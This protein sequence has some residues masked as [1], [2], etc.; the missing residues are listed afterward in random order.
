MRFIG[1]KANLTNVINN[2]LIE[3]NV[4]GTS[5]FDFFAGTASVGKFF[6]NLGFKIYS[7]DL[8]Y[9]SYVLQ[10]AYIVNNSQPEFLKLFSSI[11]IQS[12]D[13]FSSPLNSVISFLN[14][15][16]P[17][18]GFIYK[19]FT[20]EGTSYLEIP[21]MYFTGSNGKKIDAIRIEIEK[22]FTNK[23][24]SEDE[25][26]VLL[27]CLIESV[28]FFANISGVYAA[29][30]KSWDP[31]ATK[32]LALREIEII[33]NNFD[34]FSYNLNSLNLLDSI[35]CDILYLDPP[36][37][38]RQYAPNYHLL[39]TIA[40][41]DNPEIKGVSGL[42]PYEKQKSNF[43]NPYTALQELTYICDKSN[44]NYIV[45][46]YNSEG[47][48]PHDEIT[49]ILSRYGKLDFFEFDNLRYKSNSNG[50]SKEKKFIKEQ[51]FIL[52]KKSKP[53]FNDEIYSFDSPAT[54]ISYNDK[55][56]TN[57]KK[58]LWLLTEERPKS[59]VLKII[60]AEFCKDNKVV[61]FIDELRILPILENGKFL[62]KYEVA[63]V[64]FNKINKVFIKIVSGYSSFVDYLI[65][66][67]DNQPNVD[68]IPDY[69]IEETKTDDKESRNTGVYQRASKFVSIERFYPGIKKYMLYNLS[70]EQKHDPTST[71]IFGT[72][73]LLNLGVKIIGKKLD[74]SIFKK[75]DDIDE[76]I[77]FKKNMRKAPKG[78]VAIQ[79]S[80]F[81]NRI[82]VS[83]RLYKSGSIGYDPNIGSLSLIC[84][85]LRKL[86]WDKDIIVTNHGLS[87]KNVG[88]NNKFVKIANKLNI[89][90]SGIKIPEVLDSSVK[91]WKYE[92]EGEKLGTIFIHLVVENFTDGYSI[93]ENHAG[94]EKG[95]FI[96]KDGEP[97]VLEKYKN[98]KKYKAGKKNFIIHI[99]DLILID[100]GK[101]EIINVEGKKY[102]FRA[103]G[104][105]ELKNYD[106]IEKLYIKKHYPEFNIIRTVVL[107]GS[108]EKKIIEIEVGFLLNK[109]GDL[110]LGIKPPAIFKKA[111]KNLIDFWS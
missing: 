54:K 69:A 111:I 102:Q 60:I 15:I 25:Y 62:F 106:A 45:L 96:T 73:L 99:P 83:G 101:S 41:Y 44:C 5:F 20:P 84:A 57:T 1:N 47:I 76:I 74:N 78:N 71:Y 26:F 70:V 23:L 46:S 50:E 109:D 75:F 22:W 31:R 16:E 21:R 18:E 79:I 64:R 89:R 40:K 35:E 86:G 91:Y 30:Q 6:K 95:Y 81:K 36:Y 49:S 43:C 97:I 61:G 39:E 2:I 14:E 68:D 9:F 8:M 105:K 90:L 66:F 4:K 55:N 92:T 10:R 108:I 42:R 58:N 100:F 27:A 48:M 24:I 88:G 3:H 93:F 87:Q 7:S 37:N 67:M 51:I 19:N 110:I 94:C 12:S 53:V 98:R 65:F 103:N 17:V 28:P 80:K 72:R 63:G 34:N 33:S 85:V 38:Q 59:D 104:I 77:S 56:N 29:F 32:K 11:N 13:L 107:Y 52:T 82:E